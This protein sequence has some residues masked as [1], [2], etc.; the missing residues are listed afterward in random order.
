M[1]S[2][3]FIGLDVGQQRTGFARASSVAKIAEPL[4]TISTTK[5]IEKLRELIKTGRIEAIVVGL[6]RNL[7]GE[8]TNQTEWVRAWVFKAKKEIN[9]PFYAQDEA[10]TSKLAEA[11]KLSRKKIHDIDSLAASIILQDFIN[12]SEAERKTW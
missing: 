9:T 7:S 1:D 5:V 10:L 3:D 11:K 4:F 2:K 6:P 12:S 8:D